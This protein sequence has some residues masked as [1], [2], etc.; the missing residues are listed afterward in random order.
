[1]TYVIDHARGK[2]QF[3]FFRFHI[4][5][6]HFLSNIIFIHTDIQKTH[7]VLYSIRIYTVLTSEEFVGLTGPGKPGKP[8]GPGNPGGPGGPRIDSPGGPLPQNYVLQC[9]FIVFVGELNYVIFFVCRSANFKF[10]VTNT[11]SLFICSNL[12]ASLVSIMI[13]I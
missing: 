11:T 10:Y 9:K 13:M 2:R 1:M 6:S 7:F 4:T 8:A 5:I 3:F 12:Y